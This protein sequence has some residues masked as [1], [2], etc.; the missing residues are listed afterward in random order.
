M[1][2]VTFTSFSTLPAAAQSSYS[3]AYTFTTFAGV[4][5]TGNADGVGTAAQFNYP[6]GIAA[7]T[8]GNLY[9]ADT[10]NH[11]IRRISSGGVVSTIAGF[12]GNPGSADGTGRNA[13]F[14]NPSGVAL[15]NAGNLHVADT[16]NTT[17]REVIQIGTN[18][19]VV[20]IAGL[21]GFPGTNDGPGNTAKF[22]YPVGIVA[23]NLGNVYVSEFYNCTIRNLTPAGTNWIV[24]TIAGVPGQPGTNDGV[25]SVAK[26][27]GPEGLAVIVRATFMSRTAIMKPSGRF[28]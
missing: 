4:A 3:A 20:T 7:D 21:A 27:T 1:L 6:D 13:R 14:Y 5:S 12:A 23:D 15:D 22:D 17:I 28:R 18:L 19:T 9:V 11:T 16:G 24:S 10:L 26:F 2:V 25:G 8:N